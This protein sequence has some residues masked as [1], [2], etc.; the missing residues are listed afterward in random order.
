MISGTAGAPPLDRPAPVAGLALLVTAGTAALAVALGP[1]AVVIGVAALV[2]VACVLRPNVGLFVLVA[3][4]L[5]RVFDLGE[6]RYGVPSVALPLAFVL[7]LGVFVRLRGGDAVPLRGTP[8]LMLYVAIVAASSFWATDPAVTLAAGVNLLED[9]TLV[10]VLLVLLR[11]TTEVRIAVWAVLAASGT[12]AALAVFQYLSG[13]FGDDFFGFA[14]APVL[15]IVVDSDAPRVAGPYGDPNF[16]GQM[17]VTALP[18]AVERYVHETHRPLRAIALVCTALL[19]LTVI[20]TFSRG[21]LV[22]LAIVI[23]LLLHRYRPRVASVVAAS[24]LVGCLL[25]AAPPDYRARLAEIKDIGPGAAGATIDD[26]ALRGRTSEVIIAVRMFVDH[27]IAGVGYANYPVR[28]QEYNRDLGL[29]ARDEPRTPHNLALQI[30]AETGMIG[31]LAA[32]ALVV[33]SYRGLVRRRSRDGPR[34]GR[35]LGEGLAIALIGFI[36]TSMFLHLAYPRV[37]WVLI[38]V[39]LGAGQ[40]AGATRPSPAFV[41]LAPSADP[42]LVRT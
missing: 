39:C 22:G 9:L 4:L 15:N 36:V 35:G 27:P 30:A 41:P 19:V 18:L 7:A 2:G 40:A 14:Q 5:A 12:V 33:T 13:Q 34:P 8:I 16:F 26:P 29:D 10:V 23:A 38:G 21:S 28:Y 25:W 20:F 31:L 1:R 11:T 24:V 17:M 6:Q 37:F 32:T 3:A 42:T